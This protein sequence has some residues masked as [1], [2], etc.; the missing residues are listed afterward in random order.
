MAK[1]RAQ[2]NRALR[3]EALRDSLEAQGHLQHVFDC[4]NKLGE[5][6]LEAGEVTRLRT[7]ADIHLKLVDKY[8]PSLKAVEVSG[9]GGG[10]IATTLTVTF[11]NASSDS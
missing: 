6:G 9:N 8:L 2:Q 7:K 1:T 4:A 11:V 10:D 5:P 3:Q